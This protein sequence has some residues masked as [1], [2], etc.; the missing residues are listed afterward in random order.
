MKHFIN[1][2]YYSKDK[3][4]VDMKQK[5]ILWWGEAKVLPSAAASSEGNEEGSAWGQ[6][7]NCELEGQKE[8]WAMEEE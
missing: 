6:K 1:L 5:I 8:D 4:S 7:G 3:D 2:V